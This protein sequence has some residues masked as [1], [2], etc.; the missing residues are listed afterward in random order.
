MII[1]FGRTCDFYY[2]IV[3]SL[4]KC[5][6]FEK[7]RCEKQIQRHAD[8]E[9]ET[10]NGWAYERKTIEVT[11]SRTGWLYVIVSSCTEIL[12]S[13]HPLNVMVTSVYTFAIMFAF[14]F[15]KILRSGDQKRMANKVF[16]MRFELGTRNYYYYFLTSF[17]FRHR[18]SMEFQFIWTNIHTNF[19]LH[20]VFGREIKKKLESFCWLLLKWILKDFRASDEP[21][22]FSYSTYFP[23]FFFSRACHM[24]ERYKW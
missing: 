7:D 11:F 22:E 10:E 3:R 5:D 1:S 13:F 12:S 19:A 14:C 18:S 17:Y 15:K 4:T 8:N 24:E 23:D 21:L 9:K 20:F 6:R 2:F 16:S